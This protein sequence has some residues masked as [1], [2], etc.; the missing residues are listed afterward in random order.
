MW[1]YLHLEDSLKICHIT[2][3]Y[4]HMC[5]HESNSE[6]INGHI[7]NS[8]GFMGRSKRGLLYTK[9]LLINPL[10]IFLFPQCSH[11]MTAATSMLSLRPHKHILNLFQ[12]LIVGVSQ[13]H[14]NVP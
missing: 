7:N 14:C 5:K 11:F 9:T 10:K 2:Q 8:E 12:I 3:I 1:L 13:L 4:T 6:D